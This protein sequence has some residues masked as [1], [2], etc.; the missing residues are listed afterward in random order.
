M[1]KQFIYNTIAYIGFMILFG[2]IGLIIKA[3]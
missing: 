2:I 1:L 3:L